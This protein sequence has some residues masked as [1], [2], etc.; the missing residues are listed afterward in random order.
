MTKARGSKNL[1]RKTS[2]SGFLHLPCQP[3]FGPKGPRSAGPSAAG[4]VSPTPQRCEN[5]RLCP[6]CFDSQACPAGLPRHLFQG[7]GNGAHITAPG[8][9]GSP[10][11]S[12][13]RAVEGGRSTKRENRAAFFRRGSRLVAFGYSDGG[14]V[15]QGGARQVGHKRR[16][17]PADKTRLAN[18]LRAH[19]AAFKHPRPGLLRG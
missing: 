14:A 13:P 6:P 3:F 5:P 18:W 1:R 11:F 19:G 7:S 15:G 2:D 17:R 4:L 10:G 16:A 8:G 9:Q 12:G